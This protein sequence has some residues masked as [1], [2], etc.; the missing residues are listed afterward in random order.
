M[1]GKSLLGLLIRMS[2]AKLARAVLQAG[3]AGA[4]E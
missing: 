4:G 2:M 3:E 1:S